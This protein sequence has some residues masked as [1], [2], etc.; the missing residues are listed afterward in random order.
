MINTGSGSIPA[1]LWCEKLFL[2]P[3]RSRVIC[4]LVFY[5]E[6]TTQEQ[7]DDLAVLK[8]LRDRGVTRAA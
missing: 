8:R 6:P 4:C 2:G 5:Q 1:Y 3:S 7:P